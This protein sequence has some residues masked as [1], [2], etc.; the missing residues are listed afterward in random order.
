MHDRSKVNDCNKICYNTIYIGTPVFDVIMNFKELHVTSST[1][2]VQYLQKENTMLSV[3]KISS[4]RLTYTKDK[5]IILKFIDVS[6]FR[7]VLKKCLILIK[8]VFYL[9]WTGSVE[10][11]ITVH[12]DKHRTSK[13]IEMIILAVYNLSVKNSITYK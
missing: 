2:N 6:L 11:Q 9:E 1:F 12:N 10:V 5:G 13:S 3:V 7:I 4:I 8:Q